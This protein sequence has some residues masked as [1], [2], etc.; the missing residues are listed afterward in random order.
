MEKSKI[1]EERLPSMLKLYILLEEGPMDGMNLW[2]F[3][4]KIET[5]TE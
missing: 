4:N 5:M 1:G 2:I 3:F